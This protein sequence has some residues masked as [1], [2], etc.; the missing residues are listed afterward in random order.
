M[1][2][3]APALVGGTRVR[4]ETHIHRIKNNTNKFFFKKEEGEEQKEGGVEEQE[5][6]R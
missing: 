2:P 5:K 1:P 4:I 3:W 6:T